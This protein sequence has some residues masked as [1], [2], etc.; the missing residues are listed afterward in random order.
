LLIPG[1]ELSIETKKHVVVLNPGP[2]VESIHTFS[3]LRE[4]KEKNPEC[5]IF[6]PHPFFSNSISLGSALLP[7]IQLF[8]AIESSWCYTKLIDFNK[9]AKRIAETHSLPYI[10]TGDTHFL[11]LLPTTYIE[12]EANEKTIQ[13]IF[14][15]IRAG[16]F[17]NINP[18]KS[19]FTQIIPGSVPLILKAF[20]QR[21]KKPI[22]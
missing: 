10:A 20:L 2:D 13:E 3:A 7:H 14:H 16:Y 11:F 8:D 17:T 1:I 22:Q 5:F 18:P 12:I 21:K 4:H 9:K 6:A 15:A 19:F